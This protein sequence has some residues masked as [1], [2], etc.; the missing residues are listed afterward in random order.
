MRNQG[1]IM[2]MNCV[3]ETARGDCRSSKPLFKISGQTTHWLT[4]LFDFVAMH[5]VRVLRSPD[6]RAPV[7]LRNIGEGRRVPQGKPHWR[8]RQRSFWTGQVKADTKFPISTSRRRAESTVMNIGRYGLTGLRSQVSKWV[9]CLSR[10]LVEAPSLSE[11]A[12]MFRHAYPCRKCEV[13]LQSW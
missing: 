5:V 10:Q 12:Y 7:L 13:Q 6:N 1:L 3:T 4:H 11:R 8:G 2:K 9:S